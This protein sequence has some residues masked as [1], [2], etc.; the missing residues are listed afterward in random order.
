M[1]IKRLKLITYE[2]TNAKPEID[3]LVKQ[4]VLFGYLKAKGN[5][6]PD[7]EY[8]FCSNSGDVVDYVFDKD[9]GGSNAYIP[10]SEDGIQYYIKRNGSMYY[11]YREMPLVI[12]D[13][14]FKWKKNTRYNC[15]EA[16]IKDPVFEYHCVINSDSNGKV[17][18]RYTKCENKHK[19][20]VSVAEL[21]VPRAFNERFIQVIE[22][23]KSDLRKM[24]DM[25][26][27]TY[28]KVS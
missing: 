18:V 15:L 2:T 11:L 7:K 8:E 12:N 19:N 4:D 10:Y 26:H 21:D 25:E 17:I 16:T 13:Y 22:D 5:D 3:F 9:E 6:Y 20:K 1:T 24:M 14:S 23:W 27:K 28:R